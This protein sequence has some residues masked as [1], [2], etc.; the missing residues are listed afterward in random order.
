ML[1]R[2]TNYEVNENSKKEELKQICE[3]NKVIISG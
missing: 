2:D 1:R 3:N